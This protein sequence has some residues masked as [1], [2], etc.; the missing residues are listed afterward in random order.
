PDVNRRQSAF[1]LEGNAV[2]F[3]L[4]AIK[5]V[6]KGSVE[7]IV[8]ARQSGGPFVSIWDL[9]RRVDPRSINKRVLESLVLA[10]ACDSL[11]GDRAQLFEA[12][13]LAIGG[14]PERGGGQRGAHGAASASR[15]RHG[16]R[17]P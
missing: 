4:T 15:H 12:V 7:A 6:G 5:N 13:A 11:G 10:G 17:T 14:P 3:G 8:A 1:T 2:R 9:C 16:R